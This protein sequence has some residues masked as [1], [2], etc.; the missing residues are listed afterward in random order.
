MLYRW[1]AISYLSKPIRILD[2]R[3]G[4][5]D[6]AYTPGSRY[7][8]GDHDLTINGLS[9]NSVTVPDNTAGV[10]GN[11]TVL[12]AVSAE[13]IA[14]TP[15]GTGFTGTANIAYSAGQVVSNAYNSG[16]GVFITGVLP[17]LPVP[18]GNRCLHQRRG[19]RCH[20]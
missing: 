3:S 14:I 6:A 16:V 12:N 11:V 19:D 7:S 17:I 15:A 4:A 10:I 18:Y 13:F 9:Y 5:T 20:H 8:A 1:G 2:T